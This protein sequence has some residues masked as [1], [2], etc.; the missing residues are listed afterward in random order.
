MSQSLSRKRFRLGLLAVLL[1]ALGAAVLCLAPKDTPGAPEIADASRAQSL[2]YINGRPTRV[3][4]SDGDSFR[5]LEG[6]W[7]GRNTRLSGFNTLESF[8]PTHSWGNWHSFELWV[9]A[10]QATHNARHG[11]WHCFGSG[12]TDTYGRVLLDCPD[13]AIDQISKGLAHMM[14]VDDTSSRPEYIRAQHEAMR[15]RRG[16]WAHG[17][18]S[19]V[20]TSLHSADE[21]PT[22]DRHYNRL[23]STR[24]GHSE[25]WMH[26]DTYPECSY[27]CAF[28]VTAEAERVEAFARRLRSN[29]S[30]AETLEGLSNVHLIE[31]VDRY[32]RFEELPE[33]LDE[34]IANAIRPL[35]VEAH[36]SGALGSTSREVSACM[37]YTEFRRRYG[38]D[39]AWCL[40]DHGLEPPP[41]Q[42][43][44]VSN[45]GDSAQGANR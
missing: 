6:P 10:K 32:A 5:Q 35:L 1:V 23:V 33:Y 31:A 12:E 25:R 20:L 3:H 36:A 39:R 13:L 8:G 18:P 38:R 30:L 42:G 15:E 4:F 34:D 40:R 17:V 29:R 19:F 41:E 2:V 43:R 44:Q 37:V 21:D 45:G 22:R 28:V 14:Q 27:Q 16:M 26:S 9:N 7:V 24:D 11:V